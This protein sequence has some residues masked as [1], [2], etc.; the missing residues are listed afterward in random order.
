MAASRDTADVLGALRA[1]RLW[2][3]A[4]DAAISRLGASARIESAPRGTLLASEGDPADEFG[5]VVTGRLRVY[6]LNA[7]G[8]E[9]TFETVG[10]AEPVAAVAAL[11]GARYPANIAAATPVTVGS[12]A[13]HSSR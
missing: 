3:G 9:V 11:A 5:V 13:R 4:D 7:D 8:R 2:R 6:H 12:R 10:A 1:C